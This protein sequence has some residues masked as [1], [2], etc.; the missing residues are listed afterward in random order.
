MIYFKGQFYCVTYSDEVSVF[1]VAGSSVTQPI[2]ESRLLRLEDH[3][4]LF[5][6]RRPYTIQ[7]YLV[8]VDG[9]FLLVIR[10]AHFRLYD[11][12]RSSDI[13]CETFKF[14]VYELDAIKGHLTEINTL[15]GATIFL[16]LMEQFL[17]TRLSLQKSSLITYILLMIGLKKTTH[18][19]VV[20][21]KIR[22]IT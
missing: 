15:G 14:E 19:K 22:G 9:I 16:G 2:V 11:E 3:M 20:V 21:K 13:A 1:S 17:T 5:R 4:H 10:V 12:C 6:G 7:C 8:D 18:W